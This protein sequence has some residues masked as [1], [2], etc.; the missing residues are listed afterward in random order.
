MC[1]EAA[2]RKDSNEATRDATPQTMTVA[3]VRLE[4]VPPPD[5]PPGI[6]KYQPS[7]LDELEVARGL[8]RSFEVKCTSSK[9]GSKDSTIN[10]HV[11]VA[12]IWQPCIVD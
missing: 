12:C 1:L 5:A 3:L 9:L 11:S 6:S 10:N 2:Y 7:R 4:P 8:N